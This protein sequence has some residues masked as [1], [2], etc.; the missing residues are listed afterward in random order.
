[1]KRWNDLLGL[2]WLVRSVLTGLWG[3]MVEG[4][5]SG[6][7]GEDR[8]FRARTDR[9]GWGLVL[10]VGSLNRTLILMIFMIHYD[11]NRSV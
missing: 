4:W 2:R 7:C 9:T 10:E 5:K 11:L 3:E 6:K 8:P 1:M